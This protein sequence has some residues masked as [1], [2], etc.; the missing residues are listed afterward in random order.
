MMRLA[1]GMRN[2]V[3]RKNLKLPIDRRTLICAYYQ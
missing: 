1:A 3:F 2:D